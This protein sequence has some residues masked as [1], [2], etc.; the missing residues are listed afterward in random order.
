MANRN[1]PRGLQLYKANGTQD[2]ELC[3]VTDSTI[4]GKGDAVKEAG[5]SAQV[6]NGPHRKTVSRISSGTDA[7]YGV[8]MGVYNQ[9]LSGA[10]YSLDR[11]YRL[12]NVSTYVLVRRAI[13]DDVWVIQADDEGGTLVETDVELN[14]NITGNGGGTTITDCNTTSGM[15]T[16]LLD[17][18]TK[19][20]TATLQLK[21][22]GFLDQG[23]NVIGDTNPKVLVR[24]N[25]CVTSGG[26]GT[27]G[28]A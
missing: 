13:P 2:L 25:N 12:A 11:N 27:V 16:M 22:T 18:S 4:L 21:I 20:T 9:E 14:A 28:T 17:T 19:N 10:N 23:D 7:I 5:S 1:A 15:S 26:T 8:V 6:G 24:I 3:V